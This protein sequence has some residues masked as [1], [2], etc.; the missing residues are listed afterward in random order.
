MQE[1]AGSTDR[2]IQVGAAEAV[3]IPRAELSAQC[4]DGGLAIEMPWRHFTTAPGI[5]EPDA[6]VERLID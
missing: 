1:T 2:R 5:D 6:A 4:V 3:Q